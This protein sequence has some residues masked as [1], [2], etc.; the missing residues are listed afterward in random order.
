MIIW[1]AHYSIFLTVKSVPLL[2]VLKIHCSSYHLQSF[3]VPFPHCHSTLL[4]CGSA[5]SSMEQLLLLLPVEKT[6][7]V[8]EDSWMCCWARVAAGFQHSILKLW[9]IF[10]SPSSSQI[11]WTACSCMELCRRAKATSKQ[12]YTGFPHFPSSLEQ[13]KCVSKAK[14]KQYHL[15]SDYIPV[16]NFCR[17]SFVIDSFPAF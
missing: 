9:R 12:Y 4:P 15:D 13:R 10:L 7:T 2:N 6:L 16:Y 8:V 14:L 3:G 5:C 11:I 17:W 1:C